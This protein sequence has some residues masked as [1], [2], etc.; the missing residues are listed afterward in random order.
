MRW[1]NRTSKTLH[2]LS[3]GLGFVLITAMLSTSWPLRAADIQIVDLSDIDFGVVPPTAGDLSADS[4]YCV[5]MDPRGRYSLIGLGSGPGGGF[6]L[7]ER[8]TGAFG[9]NYNV[10][11]SDRGRRFSDVLQPGIALG[12][13]RA[14]QLLNNGRCQPSSRLRIVISSNQLAGAVPGR[15]QGTL[16]LLVVPE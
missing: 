5:A 16:S 6:Q 10:E 11:V 7:I 4:E 14:S 8:G 12:N 15:Y 9:I 1:P 3:T 13:Q 2:P